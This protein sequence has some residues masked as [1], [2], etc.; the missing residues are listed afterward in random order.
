MIFWEGVDNFNIEKV[1]GNKSYG[2]KIYH[3]ELSNEWITVDRSR[4][5]FWDIKEEAI[6]QTITVP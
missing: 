2:D 3:L 4:L 1:I 6:T 5:Y